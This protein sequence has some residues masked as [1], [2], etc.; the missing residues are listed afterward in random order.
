MYKAWKHGLNT[1]SVYRSSKKE[2]QEGIFK[3]FL[4]QYRMFH[5]VELT[6]Q[7][8][9]YCEKQNDQF[10]CDKS[11]VSPEQDE[12]V[13]RQC[14]DGAAKKYGYKDWQDVRANGTDEEL[15]KI[16]DDLAVSPE[17]ELLDEDITPDD[18]LFGHPD[19]GI[20][21]CW[22]DSSDMRFIKNYLPSIR[23]AMEEYH[24]LKTQLSPDKIEEKAVRLPE[25]IRAQTIGQERCNGLDEYG[26]WL[27]CFEW[28][29]KLHTNGKI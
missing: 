23:K 18:I 21:S 16:I 27:K 6:G 15:I 8:H 29:K 17:P 9:C 25:Q 1:L 26:G 2:K 10:F 4:K 24:L 12:D 3:K 11:C 22:V 7:D 28:V 13:L 14:Y 19:K 5:G 20:E